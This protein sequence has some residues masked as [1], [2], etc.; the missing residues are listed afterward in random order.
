MSIKKT[1]K[2][3]SLISRIVGILFH[4]R[5]FVKKKLVL[6][7]TIVRFKIIG[8]TGP[9]A[10]GKDEVAK[11]LRR[12][13]AFIINADQIAH[14]L[15]STQSEVWHELVK[16]FGSKILNRG[17]KVNR[18][19]LGEIVFSDKD[20][21]K[22]LNQIIHPYLKE[23]IIELVQSHQ[24]QCPKLQATSDIGHRTIVINAAVLKEIG[25][26][27]YVDEIWVAMAPQAKRLKRLLKAGLFPAEAKKRLRSQMSKKDYLKLAD[28]VIENNGPLKSLK[29]KVLN[30]LRIDN[31][32]QV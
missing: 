7:N 14:S 11:I 32:V 3:N 18:K 31:H 20:K 27:D 2:V 4:W 15:Y 28:V 22:I 10:S 29:N 8:L 6:Y 25:L 23:I 13:G 12:R 19:K 9:I 16:A 1:A 24:V 21:L 26:V 5:L 30:G 17:G